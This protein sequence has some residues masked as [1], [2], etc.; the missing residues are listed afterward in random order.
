MTTYCC[1]ET[2]R[3]PCYVCISI[4]TVGHNRQ[5]YWHTKLSPSSSERFLFYEFQDSC[6]SQQRRTGRLLES[7]KNL[8]YIYN[9]SDIPWH[10][11][12]GRIIPKI[13]D[14][15]IIGRVIS[16][17]QVDSVNE[18]SRRRHYHYYALDSKALK[19]VH[20]KS[21]LRGFVLDSGNG[22]EHVGPHQGLQRPPIP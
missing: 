4:A 22:T 6:A 12:E 7:H 1:T 9:S 17:N 2:S 13:C 18:P 16:E 19:C 21:D 10:D 11:L 5:A 3:T 14:G 20:Q 8:Q 15:E